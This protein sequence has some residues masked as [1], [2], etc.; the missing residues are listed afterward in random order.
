MWVGGKLNGMLWHTHKVLGWKW[1]WHM[2]QDSLFFLCGRVFAD[3]SSTWV[4]YCLIVTLWGLTPT[5]VLLDVELIQYLNRL[6]KQSWI[7]LTNMLV[8]NNLKGTVYK[9]LPQ[10]RLWC[11]LYSGIPVTSE[12]KTEEE[13]M[14]GCLCDP[15]CAHAL[16]CVLTCLCEQEK[17]LIWH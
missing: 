6:K 8:M 4:M 17:C 16:K 7:W 13:Y 15:L 12:W 2:L 1:Y 9:G 14:H 10:Q 5:L 3:T 11:P